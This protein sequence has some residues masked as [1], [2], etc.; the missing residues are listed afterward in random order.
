MSATWLACRSIVSKSSPRVIAR[1]WAPA[2]LSTRKLCGIPFGATLERPLELPDWV[3]S[4][5]L[6]QSPFVI[7]ASRN[8]E[9]IAAIPDGGQIPLDL[10]SRLPHAIRSIDGT[11]SGMVDEALK[12]HGLR[13]NV[14]LALPHFQGV[15]LAVAAGSHV[16]A[17]PVQFARAV[18]AQLDLMVFEPPIDVPAPHVNLYWHSRYDQDRAHLWMRSLIVTTVSELGF[19]I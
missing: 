17:V 9:A 6:F 7:I 1:Q 3:S 2:T 12:S 4:A 19:P 10:F 13:R 8:N 15:A 16:A 14:T 11:L 5:L 18:K